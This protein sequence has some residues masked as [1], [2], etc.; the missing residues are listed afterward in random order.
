VILQQ[1]ESAGWTNERH[2]TYISTMEASFLDQLYGPDSHRIDAKGSHLGGNDLKAIRDGMF[3]NIRFEGTDARMHDG[4]TSGLPD[5]L[6]IRRFRPRNASVNR[7]SGRPVDS[8]DDYGSGTD[9]VREKVRIYG[10]ETKGF[11]EQ[12][13]TGKW[14]LLHFLQIVSN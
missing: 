4:V 9:T 1:G 7:C 13:F 6:S 8:V 5:N 12:K 2:S 10:R 3:K 14:S 11:P